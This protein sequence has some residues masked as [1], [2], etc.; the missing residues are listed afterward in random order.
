MSRIS[1]VLTLAFCII[2]ESLD[3][4][5]NEFSATLSPSISNLNNLKYLLL[6]QVGGLEG[7][8]PES[9]KT[10][11]DLRMVRLEQSQMR[12][13]IFEFVSHWPQLEALDIS[14]SLFTGTI[15]HTIS[16]LENLSF[17]YVVTNVL[18]LF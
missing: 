8:L 3:L 14:Q 12:A 5:R 10:L 17:L 11:S 13:P 2:T 9:L 18:K 1:V 16:D 4:S 7:T 15:P 6:D